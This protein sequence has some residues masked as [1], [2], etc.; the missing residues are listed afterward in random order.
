MDE[1]LRL[2]PGLYSAWLRA[3]GSRIGRLTYGSPGTRVLDRTYLHVGDHVT[4]GAGVRLNGHVLMH[5]T[6]GEL[7]L[8][9]APIDVGDRALIGGYALLTAGTVIAAGEVTQACLAVCLS[10]SAKR[11][12]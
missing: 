11:G 2:V 3:W 1:A 9:L 12:R 10:S 7:Q 4:F 8:A 5:D 6:A